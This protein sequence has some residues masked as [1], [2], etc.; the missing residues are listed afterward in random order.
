MTEEE[1]D[2]HKKSLAT[3]RLEKPKMLTTLSAVFWN[4]ISSQ[5]YNFDRVN[6]EVAYLRTIMQEQLLSFFEVCIV[7]LKFCA[8]IANAF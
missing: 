3:Q 8:R 7:R 4:E 1:F 5:Q 6:I 2:R